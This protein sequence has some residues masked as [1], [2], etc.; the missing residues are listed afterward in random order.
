MCEIDWGVIAE[1]LSALATTGAVIVA[2][3]LASRD[4]QDQRAREKHEA[5]IIAGLL[6][7]DLVTIKVDAD[8]LAREVDDRRT[9]GMLE[10][11]LESQDHQRKKIAAMASN[12]PMASLESVI[13][14]L[15]VMPVSASAVLL[16]LITAVRE[17]QLTASTLY[18]MDNG[19]ASKDMSQFLPKLQEQ[20]ADLQQK[21]ED[22]IAACR[23]VAGAE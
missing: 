4:R 10:V 16:K 2:L 9:A 3:H 5:K 6:D 8:S 18:Q 13:G 1:W 7:T 14:R 23:K 21:A 17:L 22:A 20:A 11:I 12:F 15:H 19:Q